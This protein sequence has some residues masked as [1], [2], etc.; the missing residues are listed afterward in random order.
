MEGFLADPILLLKILF[1]THV[2]TK[3]ALGGVGG[4][5]LSEISRLA[6]F[7]PETRQYFQN[8]SPSCV[9]RLVSDSPTGPLAF[10]DCFGLFG[11]FFF[12][13]VTIRTAQHFCNTECQ[14]E[15]LKKK[16]R[17]PLFKIKKV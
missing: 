12:A 3:E 14:K 16:T 17:S 8:R 10:M 15:P 1:T 2:A 6:R 5:R 13:R 4:G 11:V 7:E 9:C